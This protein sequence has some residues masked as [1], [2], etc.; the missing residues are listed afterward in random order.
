M[1]SQA[2]KLKN[3]ILTDMKNLNLFGGLLLLFFSPA[4]FAQPDDDGPNDE[5]REQIRAHKVA[6]IS[7]ELNLT[8]SEAEKFWPVYNEYEKKLTAK[9]EA[10]R[11]LMKELKAISDLSAEAAYE[12]MEQLLKIEEEEVALRSEYLVKF[13]TVLDKKKAARV[14]IAE[15]K[16]KK[17]LIRIMNP[18]GPHG[19]PG[20]HGGQKP[21]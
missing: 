16:F 6:F 3:I 7:T 19:G 5:K 13:A 9:R 10:K 21:E 15:E 20:G 1:I 4:L 2:M 18:G 14:F 12:K 17:E 8:T 11:K